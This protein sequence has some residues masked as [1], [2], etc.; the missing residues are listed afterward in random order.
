MKK[1]IKINFK[2]FNKNNDQGFLCEVHN[3]F[4]M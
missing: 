4:M 1:V 3:N 2:K